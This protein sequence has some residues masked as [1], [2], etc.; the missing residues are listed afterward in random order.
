M[1]PILKATAVA[2]VGVASCLP[3]P[4]KFAPRT[5]QREV[6]SNALSG[7]PWIRGLKENPY[8]NGRARGGWFSTPSHPLPS[9]Q[10]SE[11]DR[12]GSKGH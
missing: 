10:Q 2:F 1:P 12:A 6:R 7:S 3:S 5:K 11:E 8:R 9:P 4:K